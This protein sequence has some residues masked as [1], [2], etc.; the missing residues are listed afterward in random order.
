[1][2]Q[3][4]TA[5]PLLDLMIGVVIILA[6]LFKSAFERLGLPALAGFIALGVLLRVADDTF[7]LISEDGMVVLEFLGRIGVFAI[8][9]RVGLESNLSGLL[10]KLPRAA[11]IW[12][13]NIALS[14]L[15]AYWVSYQWIGLPLIPSLFVAIAL[16]ATSIA[17]TAEIWSEAGAISSANGEL[18][19]DVAELDD[20]SAVALLAFLLALVP[21]LTGQS[22][23]TIS[24]A[25]FDAGTTFLIKTFAFGAF[26]L[27][28]ARYGERHISRFIKSTK[29][30]YGI[31][32]VAGIGIVVAAL[33]AQLGLSL[34]VGA[35][36]AG[37]IFCR[38][39]EVVSMEASFEPVHDF[40]MPFFFVVV[41]LS[42]DPMSLTSATLLGGILLIVAVL[43]KIIGAGVPAYFAAGWSGAVLIG[44]S[45][46]PRAE[47][48]LVVARQGKEL[49]EW[50]LPPEVYS[51][52]VLIVAV[53]CTV[54]PAVLRGL[55]RQWPQK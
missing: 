11:P 48:A 16:T 42:V 6:I 47:I 52:L 1:M 25:L 17:V 28:L 35:L 5:L 54:S 43:G 31:L 41:G 49:G 36:F 3:G 12:V 22:D 30:P 27:L 40:F 4:T 26:C 55:L 23:G 46:V 14:G 53:T 50:A 51:A 8:L 10:S 37:L 2:D 13:S 34:A 15:P 21:V 7:G 39:P 19:M 24:K 29:P 20:I 18:M 45:M 38:D 44:I 32:F 9:F 33:A